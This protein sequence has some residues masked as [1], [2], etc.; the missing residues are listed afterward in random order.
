MSPTYA[1]RWA[2][3]PKTRE[4]APEDLGIRLLDALEVRIDDRLEMRCQARPLEQG[5]HAAVRVRHHADTEA[6]R[7]QL[8][9][10]VG[11]SRHRDAPQVRARVLFGELDRRFS[12]RGARDSGALEHGA[13]STSR[14]DRHRGRADRRSAPRVG[15]SRA[16]PTASP[17]ASAT[18]LMSW[19]RRRAHARMNA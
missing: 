10:R 2:G 17:R 1:V 7:A 8:R 3:T 15:R 18:S 9:E 19:L 12:C 6:A 13:G 14:R 11:C 5:R 16:A 4:R